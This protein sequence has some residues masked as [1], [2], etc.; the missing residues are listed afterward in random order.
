MPER[1]VSLQQSIVASASAHGHGHT[2]AMRASANEECEREMEREEEEEEEKEVQMQRLEPA[3]ETPWNYEAVWGAST[4]MELPREAGV[5]PVVRGITEQGLAHACGI[6]WPPGLYVTSNFE[7]TVASASHS[8]V[9]MRPVRAMLLFADGGV[10]LLSE[11]EADALLELQRP[12][13][14]PGARAPGG[15]APLTGLSLRPAPLLA[16]LPFL[17]KACEQLGEPQRLS[18]RLGHGAGGCAA[19]D[20]RANNSLLPSLVALHLLD[21]GTR[22]DS[23]ELRRELHALMRGKVEAAEQLTLLRGKQTLLPRS[24]LANACEDLPL[25]E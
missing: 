20:A 8:G 4:P 6:K 25:L 22:Y 15:S 23:M 2:V 14:A 13:S 17:R 11:R 24:H 7:R 3:A 10:L 5:K 19:G 16:S 12:G 9:H 18:F 1:L 21:G